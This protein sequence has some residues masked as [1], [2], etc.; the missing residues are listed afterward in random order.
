MKFIDNKY[1]LNGNGIICVG[2]LNVYF[3]DYI[4]KE[5]IEFIIMMISQK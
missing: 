4:C 1:I 5:I 3:V 2:T